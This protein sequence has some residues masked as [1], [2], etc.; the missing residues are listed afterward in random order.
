VTPEGFDHYRR[1]KQA[2]ENAVAQ[3]EGETRAYIE[4]DHFRARFTAA[5]AKWAGAE[6]LLWSSDN[7]HDVTTVGH[8]CRE[9]MQ[10]FA[11]ALLDA[12]PVENVDPDVTHTENRV[13]AVVNAHAP[14]SER[15]RAFLDALVE[16]WRKVSDLAQR[17]VHGAG[18]EGES[19][20]WEDAR[21]LVFQ[22]LNVMYE[23]SR[24]LNL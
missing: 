4:A 23:V 18:K 21:R 7:E 24:A 12:R 22:T 20:V 15:V 9:A 6:R 11:S 3:V 13:R 16:Y 8:L 17:Q 5:H 1:T 19:L 10:E 14:S 2:A